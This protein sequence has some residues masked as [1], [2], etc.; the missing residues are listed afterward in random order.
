VEKA[1]TKNGD[2]PRTAILVTTIIVSI[3]STLIQMNGNRAMLPREI[4]EANPE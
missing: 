1:M 4:A 2:N 3:I